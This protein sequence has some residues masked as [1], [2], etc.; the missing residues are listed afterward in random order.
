MD[1]EE[2]LIKLIDNRLNKPVSV[3]GT[4]KKFDYET[5]QAMVLLAGSSSAQSFINRSGEWLSIGDT[6]ETEFSAWENRIVKRFGVPAPFGQVF[7]MTQEE[8]DSLTEKKENC[9]YGII[10]EEQ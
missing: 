10:Q 2:D 5:N 9:L 7:V 1:N 3:Y 6:V 4:V 8:Y